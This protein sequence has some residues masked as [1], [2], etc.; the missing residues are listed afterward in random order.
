MK[1]VRIL[2]R[3]EQGGVHADRGSLKV[4]YIHAGPNFVDPIILGESEVRAGLGDTDLGMLEIRFCSARWAV[5]WAK[6][7]QF[8][9]QWILGLG[10][11]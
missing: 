7:I 6:V 1:H 4:G 8:K 2:R 9:G 5:I 11:R 10:Q 3:E